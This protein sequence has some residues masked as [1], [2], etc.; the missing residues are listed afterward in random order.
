[1]KRHILSILL[2]A[3]SAG[4]W[5]QNPVEAVIRVEYTTE[6][7]NDT[8]RDFSS[9]G[10][11]TFAFVGGRG[12]GQ[13]ILNGELVD[14][15][16]VMEENQDL[17]AWT[18]KTEAF[19]VEIVINTMIKNSNIGIAISKKSI[20]GH[21]DCE[22]V[23]SGTASGSKMNTQQAGI[24]NEKVQSAFLFNCDNGK[25]APY[26]YHIKLD[27]LG[28]DT[29]YYFQP[30]M[31]LDGKYMWG[32]EKSFV[33]P[34]TIEGALLHDSAIGL[35]TSYDAESGVCLSESAIAEL[36]DKCGLTNDIRRVQM[37]N[38]GKML[39]AV[40]TPDMKETLKGKASN[41]ID[42]VDGRI[43]LVKS[44]P[45]D[46]LDHVCAKLAEPVMTSAE[47]L[48]NYDADDRGITIYTKNCV[49]PVETV[50][51]PADSDVPFGKYVNGVPANTNSN[52]SL[53]INTPVGLLPG[54][55]TFSVTFAPD[56]VD[57][58]NK[59][60]HRFYT[61]I[62]E[63]ITSGAN[64]GNYPTTGVRIANPDGSGN[65]FLTDNADKCDTVSFDYTV[66]DSFAPIIIQFQSQVTSKLKDTYDR[67]L[68]VA[69]IE[70]KP[71]K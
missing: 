8:V 44:I 62:F 13:H 11:G 5:A 42:C 6:E 61:Y 39:F 69:S 48:V 29:K 40:I 50:S 7:G 28:Y 20:N 53:G 65:Y 60:T 14:D 47:G 56:Y 46:I 38:A 22:L 21:L 32:E 31:I 59:R 52:V 71:K 55:Y 1:M 37:S 19:S 12:I 68:R 36:L 24:N 35:N 10:S 9:I 3:M 67:G 66:S 23:S 70:V 63:Q 17:Y 16:G 2:F 49:T 58:E 25:D 26:S 45:A 51:C 4:L 54:E 15:N 27:N 57:R 34:R 64:A 18:K 33:T 30:F 43:Y 41:V